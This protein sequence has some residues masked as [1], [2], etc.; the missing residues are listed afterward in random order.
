MRRL[1]AWVLDFFAR[2]RAR[3]SR[4]G[5]RPTRDFILGFPQQSVDGPGS[6]SFAVEAPAGFVVMRLV[7]PSLVGVDFSVVGFKVNGK[8]IFVGDA[9]PAVVFSETAGGIHLGSEPVSEKNLQVALIVHNN[10]I[11]PRNFCAA[12]VGTVPH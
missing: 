7:I 8:N 4:R 9:I 2:L 11:G 5:P 1:A 10:A 12:I 3:F 6:G